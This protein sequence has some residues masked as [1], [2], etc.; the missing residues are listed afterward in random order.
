[1]T[2]TR[3]KTGF[4]DVNGTRTYYEIAGSGDPLVLV[5][6]G[7]ADSRMWDEQFEVLAREFTVVRYDMRGYG[8]TLAVEGPFAYHRDLAA[9]LDH[10]GIARAILLGCS[11]GGRTIIDLALESPEWVA[12]LIAVAPGVSGY[13]GDSGDP[14]QREALLGA[15]ERGDLEQASEYEVQIWVDG[16]RRGTDQVPAAI[17]DRVREMNLIPLA[18]PDELGDERPL[19][20]PAVGRL[21]EILA[22]MLIVVGELD[23]P[24]AIEQ[25][26][27]IAAHVPHAE[28][29]TLTTAH[30]PNMERADEFNEVVLTFL[31]RS[32]HSR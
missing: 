20:P 31:R 11:M 16:P 9:L 17:R 28:T 4:A 13:V 2:D 32:A 1:M 27:F 6:A 22:P 12:A 19:D 23:Q 8:K 14:P 7:I 24:A 29:V 5:H 18:V 26:G 3:I 15:Y 10:L 30:L 25:S 21:H